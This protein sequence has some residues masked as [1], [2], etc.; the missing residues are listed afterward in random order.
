MIFYSVRW[1]DPMIANLSNGDRIYSSPP[2]GS[3][4]ITASIIKIFGQFGFSPDQRIDAD[5][6][7]KL[8]ETMKFLYAQRSKIGDPKDN[9]Y[10][11]EI[12]KVNNIK[13]SY[14]T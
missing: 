11:E 10:K 2:P 4:A 3:G 8:V 9:T 5:A 12:D 1:Q 7:L 14:S 13:L 6:Y